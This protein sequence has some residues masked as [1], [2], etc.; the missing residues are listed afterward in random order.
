MH[1]GW[2]E[3]NYYCISV[4]PLDG[5][6][7]DGPEDML[8]HGTSEE[9]YCPQGEDCTKVKVQVSSSFP[10]SKTFCESYVT[11]NVTVQLTAVIL[12]GGRGV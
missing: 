12:S 1:Y 7:E 8:I 3:Q 9:H 10:Y 4:E 11:N 6:E 2:Q 5:D